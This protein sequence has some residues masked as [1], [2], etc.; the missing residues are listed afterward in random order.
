MLKVDQGKSSCLYHT[1][2]KVN[3]QKGGSPGAVFHK[4]GKKGFATRKRVKKEIH[5]NMS[6]KI[7]KGEKLHTNILNF[8][9]EFYHLAL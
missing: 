5:P 6:W 2:I 9:C 1:V 4:P 8:E 7:N 3:P